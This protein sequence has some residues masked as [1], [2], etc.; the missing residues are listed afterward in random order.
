MLN[1]SFEIGRSIWDWWITELRLIGDL[2]FK[3]SRSDNSPRIIIRRVD[4][5]LILEVSGAG[6]EQMLVTPPFKDKELGA[7][8]REAHQMEPAIA[9]YPL[10]FEVSTQDIITQETIRPSRDLPQLEALAR[11]DLER[12]TPLSSDEVY[13]AVEPLEVRN[14]STKTR[15][16]I[17]K[18]ETVAD[19]LKLFAEA[20]QNLS[21]LTVSGSSINLLDH[22]GHSSIEFPRWAGLALSVLFFADRKSVV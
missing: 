15:D 8:I 14:A 22:L 1:R 16:I 9:D 21:T 6:G 5:D 20:D 12:S 17:I 19:I 4:A 13:V 11:L 18:K 2:I 10:A 3:S 7:I